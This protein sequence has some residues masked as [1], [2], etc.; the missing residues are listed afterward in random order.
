VGSEIFIRDIGYIN[1]YIH[2]Y[3]Y[4]YKKKKKKSTAN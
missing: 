3:I 2:I 4:I 1:T